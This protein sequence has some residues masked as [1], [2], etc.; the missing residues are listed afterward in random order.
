MCL[1]NDQ[2]SSQL[3]IGLSNNKSPFDKNVDRL[4]VPAGEHRADKIDE[5]VEFF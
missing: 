4:G 5:P 2:T 1:S 3:T